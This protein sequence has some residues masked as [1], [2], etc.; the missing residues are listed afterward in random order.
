MTRVRGV[1]T[2]HHTRPA[3]RRRGGPT[4]PIRT[5]LRASHAVHFRLKGPHAPASPLPQIQEWVH[6][7][8]AQLMGCR[9]LS[10][11]PCF[12]CRTRFFEWSRA[13]HAQIPIGQADGR[14]LRYR[15][16]LAPSA[17]AG[18]TTMHDHIPP[19][20]AKSKE[21]VQ[22]GEVERECDSNPPQQ[23]PCRGGPSCKQCLWN[24]R[25]RATNNSIRRPLWS[26]VP[27]AWTFSQTIQ[28]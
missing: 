7:H 15:A 11:G 24:Q 8:F 6:F 22:E 13:S 9:Y 23:K 3:A 19:A 5:C 21:S 25:D 27:T 20:C 18:T 28:R 4:H 10:T 1:I 17:V 26:T 14:P 16:R 12:S 2:P